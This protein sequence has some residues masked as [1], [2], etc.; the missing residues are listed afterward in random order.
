LL[1]FGVGRKSFHARKGRHGKTRHGKQR[2]KIDM[3]VISGLGSVSRS[4]TGLGV[5]IKTKLAGFWRATRKAA[6]ALST[7]QSLAEMDD[8]M[9]A[10]LGI[11]RAQ[12]QFELSRSAWHLAAHQAKRDGR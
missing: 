7:R 9:L 4:G 5:G 6:R 2:K 3:S 12:A 11:S 1:I 10:D 8:R